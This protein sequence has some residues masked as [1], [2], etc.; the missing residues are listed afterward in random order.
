[1]DEN[2]GPMEPWQIRAFPRH[3][4]ERIA[5]D[6][7]EQK[8]T[9]GDLLTKIL[10][11]HYSAAP[12][13]RR[14]NGFANTSNMDALDRAVGI[15]C[16]LAEHAGSMPKGVANLAYGLVKADLRTLKANSGEGFTPRLTHQP[17]EVESREPQPA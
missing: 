6:A 3:L 14:L 4:R 12:D 15:A 8:V 7:G 2:L 1:M 11:A 10:L 17:Q 9:V 5:K 16:R 13:N